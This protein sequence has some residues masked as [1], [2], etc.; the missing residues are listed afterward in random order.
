MLAAIATA[1]S[2]LRAATLRLEASAGNVANIGSRGALPPGAPQAYQPVRVEQTSMTRPGGAGG[3]T[4]AAVR[5]VS[6]AWR[7]A[8]DPGAGFA[9]ASGMV[10][11][12]NVDL[13]GETLEQATAKAAF[14]ANLRTLQTAQDMVRRLYELTD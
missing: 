14:M 1:V 10:A 12:P 9:D 4:M 8:Y 3:G 2:G 11:E 5:N 13:I 7:A 6:P